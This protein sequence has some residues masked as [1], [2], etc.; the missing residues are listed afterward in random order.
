LDKKELKQEIQSN[1]EKAL[2]E[3]NARLLKENKKL[4]R[5][6]SSIQSL[7]EKFENE[8]GKQTEK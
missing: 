5:L 8:Y 4:E 2:K 6:I 7:R 3:G 1:L